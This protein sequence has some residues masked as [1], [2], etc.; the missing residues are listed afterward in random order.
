MLV[1]YLRKGLLNDMNA[2][3]I[4]LQVYQG[5]EANISMA[6][7]HTRGN[8]DILFACF[9]RVYIAHIAYVSVLGASHS[10]GCFPVW[11]HLLGLSSGHLASDNHLQPLHDYRK[12]VLNE[13]PISHGGYHIL[14][15]T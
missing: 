4:I 11:E 1:K 12:I 3:G 10:H 9:A 5:L 15:S 14:N 8:C 7:N 13:K 2:F 6:S